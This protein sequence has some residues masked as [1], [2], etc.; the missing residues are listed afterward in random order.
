[1][2]CA[3]A[4][5]QA[6][7]INDGVGNAKNEIER[8]MEELLKFDKIYL[9]LDNMPDG[10]METEKCLKILPMGKTYTI[11]LVEYKDANEVLQDDPEL[12]K[13]ILTKMEIKI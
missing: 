12:L 6:V 5:F 2:S 10:R 4:G 3:E 1:M 11:D 9:C 7:S 13:D 8:W